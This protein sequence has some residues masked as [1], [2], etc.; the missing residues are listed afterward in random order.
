MVYR[1]SL[2]KRLII[3][4]L[5]ITTLVIISLGVVLLLSLQAYFVIQEQNFLE[6]NVDDISRQAITLFNRHT[7]H[8][9]IGAQMQN[10]AFLSQVR[11]RLL[12]PDE[13]VISDTGPWEGM[14]IGMVAFGPVTSDIVSDTTALEKT[15]SIIVVNPTGQET[16]KM[17]VGENNNII[18]I[19]TQPL[20]EN[21]FGLKLDN[22]T[23]RPAIADVTITGVKSTAIEE[24][25]SSVFGA[26]RSVQ[27]IRRE[28]K[29]EAGKL[30]AYLEVSEGPSYG[31]DI[32]H[33]VA[34]S[35]GLAVLLAIMAAV[36]AGWWS[37]RWISS[38]LVTLSAAAHQMSH[39]DMDTRVAIKGGTAE[40]NDLAQSFNHMA[41]NLQILIDSLKHFIADAA[42]QIQTPVTAI[43]T[44]LE[45]L[46]SENPSQPLTRLLVQVERMQNLID[47]LLTLSRLETGISG[48]FRPVDLSR[49]LL[50]L[51]EVY[52]TR[53]EQ[54]GQV[55]DLKVQPG[56]TVPAYE[57]SLRQAFENIL[58]N[59]IKFTQPEGRI[60]LDMQKKDDQIIIKVWDDGPAIPADEA[61]RIFER[62]F[63]GRNSSA[64]PGSGIGL[65]IVKTAID[66][67]QGNI[68]VEN[69]VCGGVCFTISLP[70]EKAASSDEKNGPKVEAN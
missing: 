3:S 40:F 8:D 34:L 20:Q 1:S 18:S 37:S 13:S 30:V 27:V 70:C 50:D 69:L 43:R 59:A 29:D 35:L 10:L 41:D 22:I 14:R 39:G 68:E 42:H 4:Y 36:V 55:F 44:D 65:A 25:N 54:K 2:R 12:N 48:N 56:V 28:L 24:S 60:G 57:D 51:G 26:G 32:L 15:T 53:A 38:P 7:D 33:T 11:I 9:L 66:Q 63:R 58:D 21:I 6:S 46:E 47:Q 31:G 23:I 16:S 45:V 61:S 67:H 52:A 64:I 19:E 5:L 62:F 49:M 17:S